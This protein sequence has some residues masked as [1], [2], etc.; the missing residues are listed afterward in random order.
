MGRPLFGHC[1]LSRRDPLCRRKLC[2]FWWVGCGGKVIFHPQ[3]WPSCFLYFSL[4]LFVLLIGCL[5]FGLLSVLS[6]SC[7]S[8]SNSSWWA[9]PSV[10]AMLHSFCC[11]RRRW[12]FLLAGIPLMRGT[13]KKFC[14][15]LGDWRWDWLS[16]GLHVVS[17]DCVCLE[18]Q[19]QGLV[20]TFQCVCTNWIWG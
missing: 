18:S 8:P 7:L 5:G 14:V 17:W 6:L 3:S 1:E 9:S 11:G 15:S 4:M 10:L 19:D 12:M 16:R 2:G 20:S 13:K